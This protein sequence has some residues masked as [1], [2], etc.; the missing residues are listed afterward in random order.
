MAT[1]R[2]SL[3]VWERR[4]GSVEASTT[5]IYLPRLFV[6]PAY[7]RPSGRG[8]CLRQINVAL[9]KRYMY[10]F[11]RCVPASACSDAGVDIGARCVVN[12]YG[13]RHATR[14]ADAARPKPDTRHVADTRRRSMLSG[15]CCPNLRFPH[16]RPAPC[17]CVAA[18]LHPCT[19]PDTRSHTSHSSIEEVPPRTC[20]S[21]SEPKVPCGGCLTSRLLGTSRCRV[22][23]TPLQM[24]LVSLAAILCCERWGWNKEASPP[25]PSQF[26]TSS[27]P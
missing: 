3:V 24:L 25:A 17:A 14:R 20:G 12:R 26:S 2:V 8:R 10:L 19:R 5:S 22:A 21:F 4:E 23:P 9:P 6:L 7:P 27:W 16:H 1:R 13:R 11:L 15:C 18:L